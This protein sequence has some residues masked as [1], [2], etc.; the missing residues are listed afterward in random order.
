MDTPFIKVC[1]VYR[2]EGDFGLIDVFSCKALVN[3]PIKKGCL[4]HFDAEA[5]VHPPFP[6]K[7]GNSFLLN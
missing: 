3:N 7:L 2:Q 1:C 4:H 5:G 6:K